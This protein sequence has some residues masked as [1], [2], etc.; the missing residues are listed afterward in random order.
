MG[1]LDWSLKALYESFE[2]EEF[3]ADLEA[4]DKDIAEINEFVNQSIKTH[5]NEASKLEDYIS[6]TEKIALLFEKLSVFSE[7]TMSVNA[8][9][10]QANRYADIVERKQSQLSAANTKMS[11]WI[12]EIKN[13][14]AVI[15]ESDKLKQFAF[16][17]KEINS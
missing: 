9:D 6:K 3:K 15:T 7:L 8:K 14:D 17:I 13:I 12:S 1:Q 10:E 4:L 5:E 16:Y 11:K 2:C